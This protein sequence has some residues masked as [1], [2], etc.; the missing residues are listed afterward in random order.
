MQLGN[1]LYEFKCFK[2]FIFN[3]FSIQ[4][5]LKADHISPQITTKLIHHQEYHHNALTPAKYK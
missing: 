1:I 3:L 4:L 5:L 2:Y